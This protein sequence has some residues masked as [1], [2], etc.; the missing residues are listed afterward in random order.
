MMRSDSE[1]AAALRVSL[2]PRLIRFRDVSGHLGMDRNRFNSEVR[3]Y[4][5]EIPIGEQ[6]IAFDRLEVDAWVDQ[7]KS[8]N[9]RPGHSKGETLWD[10]KESLGSTSAMES[11]TS[12]NASEVF[13]FARALEKASS[14]RRKHTLPKRRR[15]LDRRPSTE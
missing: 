11:G 8:R 12:T 7:Y 9:G 15:K 10:A 14:Q 2:L 4:L 5:T 1:M 6:G 13:E 3:P